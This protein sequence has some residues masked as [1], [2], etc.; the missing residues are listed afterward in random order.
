VR[1]IGGATRAPPRALDEDSAGEDRHAAIKSRTVRT[2]RLSRVFRIAT[3]YLDQVL[4][5]KDPNSLYREI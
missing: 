5:G 3:G 2:V 4:I 1:S